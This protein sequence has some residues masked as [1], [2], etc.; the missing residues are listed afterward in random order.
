MKYTKWLFALLLATILVTACKK[1]KNDE[2]EE[3][4]G[5]VTIRDSILSSN[6]RLPW[7]ITW[8][9][10]NFIWITERNG[11][12]SRMNAAT[13]ETSTVFNVPDV[14]AEGEGGLLGMVL[15]GNATSPQ[16]YIV[17][18]YNQSGYKE[19]VVRYNYAAGTLSS[20]LTI[21]ENIPASG[22]HNGSRLLIVGDKLFI[23]TGDANAASRAQD[24]NSLNGKI[25]RLNLDGTIP[26]DNPV[27]G[28]PYWSMGHRNPQGLVFANDK[29]YS[30]EHGPSNDDEVNIIS[31][32]GNFGWP[33]VE[34]LCNT[35][36]EQTFCAANNV[37]Q[38]IKTWTPTTAPSGL[39][40]YNSNQIPQWKG[41]LLL[42]ALKDARLYQL[43]LNAGNDAVE[44]TT[45]FFNN[46]YGRL[47]DLCISPD[48]EVYIC[49]SN[50]NNDM[51][52]KVWGVAD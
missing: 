29:I 27:N 39:D 18:N 44:T 30:S 9:P 38:P 41:S 23:S 47:R 21:I 42:T 4:S 52:I 11:R 50:G 48:G 36:S 15:R 16:V 31:K 35:A 40:Y 24:V 37:I 45:E 3:P 28:N 5:P 2:P 13:A 6:L 49:T 43:K 33:D 32:G 19:K 34:G 8:G 22:I 14:A 7:E 10:D 51:I 20:P 17:Y 1:D 12:I 25:L 46:K 26:S